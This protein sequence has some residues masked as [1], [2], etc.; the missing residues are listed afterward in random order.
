MFSTLSSVFS[1][2]PLTGS[3]LS[4]SANKFSTL[5]KSR[6][7][8][9]YIDES[10]YLPTFNIEVYIYTQP[11]NESVE[12]V[13]LTIFPKRKSFRGDLTKYEQ[14]FIDYM[15]ELYQ[16]NNVNCLSMMECF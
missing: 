3:A 6:I 2:N 10:L 5:L 14:D 11:G 13:N 4:S 7:Y 15:L 1:T 16:D 8:G 9:N 12:K